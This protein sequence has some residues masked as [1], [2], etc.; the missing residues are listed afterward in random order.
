M[1]TDEGSGEVL[2]NA[3]SPF[4]PFSDLRQSN[5]QARWTK[6]G[7]CRRG[8]RSRPAAA[9]SPPCTPATAPPHA[10][11]R[12][13]RSLD[14][15]PRRAILVVIPRRR[16]VR[17]PLGCGLPAAVWRRLT[18]WTRARVVDQLYLEVLDRLGV[19]GGLDRSR[20]SVDTMSVRAR[21]G[22]HMG[23]NPVDRGK[24]GSKLQLVCDGQ[25]L[26]LALALTAANVN[27]S[28]VFQGLLDDVPAADAVGSAALPAR[29]RP[30]GTGYDAWHCRAY[31]AGTG[32]R[33]GSLGEESSPRSGWDGIGGGWSGRCRG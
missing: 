24:P 10:R 8:V 32:S 1:P 15:M 2:A 18:E 23:A 22:D 11:W 27:H 6:Q 33:P 20:A 9:G 7:G 19:G 3:F 14:S 25:G 21:R 26:P 5:A 29:N 16:S 13:S 12:P 31:C 17:R 4:S 28:V 30:C